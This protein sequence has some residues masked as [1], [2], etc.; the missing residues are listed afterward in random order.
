MGG[1]DESI[2][3]KEVKAEVTINLVGENSKG[4]FAIN[5]NEGDSCQEQFLKKSESTQHENIK[6]PK[7]Q[8]LVLDIDGPNVIKRI[9]DSVYKLE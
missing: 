7:K 5:W 2:I 6:E 3:K 9:I 8:R 1:L 4:T